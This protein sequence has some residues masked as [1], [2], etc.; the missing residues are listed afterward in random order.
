MKKSVWI[1]IEQSDGKINDVSWEL[2]GKGQELAEPLQAE[3]C[4]IILGHE[5]KEIASEPIA[6]GADKVYIIDDPLLGKYRT[7]PYSKGIV[8][9]AK[10]YKPEILLMGATYLGRDLSGAVATELLTG[11][12]ADCTRLEID[13]ETGLLNQTRPAFGGNIMATICCG[14]SKPQ[15]ATVRP[16]VMNMPDRDE[17][18]K[19]SIIEE[20][21]NVKEEDIKTNI[22]DFIAEAGESFHIEDSDVIVAGGRGLGEAKNFAM[23]EELADVL[24]ATVG[25]SRP[26]VD[27]GWITV[28][29]QVGQTG[30]TVRP[31]LYIACGISGA[32]QHRV[33]MEGSDII[34][35]I[36][37]DPDAGIFKFANYGIV[38]DLFE[39]VPAL[40]K[41]FN[42]K[43]GA[44]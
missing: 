1:F 22:V 43:K 30:H 2:L 41:A 11:L 5:I 20:T 10:K 21:L 33:G 17:S 32:V 38:G 12:T 39:V 23:L 6:Y 26:P 9:L 16:R 13:S 7:Y 40:T 14:K 4:G 25:A 18:L 27:A 36:N 24:G 3:L 28:A 29:H 42:N 19:G 31:K 35:A 37:N 44:K 34:V 8:S 15:M